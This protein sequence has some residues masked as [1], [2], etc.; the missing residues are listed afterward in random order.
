MRAEG[1]SQM[2]VMWGYSVPDAANTQPYRLFGVKGSAF[3][4]PQ[5][6]LGG[7]YLMTDNSG[8][9]PNGD[10]FRYSI[11]GIES[12][13]H[14]PN[15]GGE[16]VVGVRVGMTKVHGKEGTTDL[17]YSPYHY[18]LAVGYDWYLFTK[19]SFGFE[20]SYVHVLKGRTTYGTGT[21]E[22]SPFD[23]LNFMLTLQFRL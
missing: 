20:G 14:I 13:Y 3:L 16:T 15:S 6:T 19:L 12:S 4:T 18:G 23:M 1:G 11:H 7:Y 10:K 2:G 17:V 5:I 9:P 21:I 8:Q 22:S